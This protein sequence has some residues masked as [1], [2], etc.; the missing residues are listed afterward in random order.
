MSSSLTL[1]ECSE[2][3][4]EFVRELRND[5]R[6]MDGFISRKHITAEMQSNYMSKKSDCYRIALYNN[7]PAG[8]IG[9]IDNDIRVCTHPDFQGKGIGK[10][11]VNKVSDI[12][13][14]AMAKVKVD[15]IASLKLFEASGFKIEYYL[16]ALK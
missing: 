6:V 11:M 14:N 7:L 3:F 8:Y 12:W 10:F 15:N 1:I 5:P 13:P 4:W 9:V 2:Q 16:L